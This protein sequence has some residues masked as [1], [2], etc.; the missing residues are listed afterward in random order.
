[1]TMK[2]RRRSRIG[3]RNAEVASD[4]R[5]LLVDGIQCMRRHGRRHFES[6]T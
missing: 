4:A 1:M 5:L 3:Q 2:L 6:P